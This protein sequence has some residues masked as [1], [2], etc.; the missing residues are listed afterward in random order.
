MATPPPIAAGTCPG[1]VSPDSSWNAIALN[2]KRIG[3]AVSP[4]SGGDREGPA[5]KVNNATPAATIFD[6]KIQNSAATGTTRPA[7]CPTKSESDT[8]V[9]VAARARRS[10]SGRT[11]G[12]WFVGLRRNGREWTPNLLDSSRRRSG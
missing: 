5:A 3:D 11:Y 8:R 7:R 6:I 1:A 10:R 9:V 12:R 4:A 2:E